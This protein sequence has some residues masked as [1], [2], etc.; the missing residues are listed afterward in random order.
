MGSANE[1]IQKGLQKV[2]DKRFSANIY[3][4]PL[5]VQNTLM[6]SGSS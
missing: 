1:L 4:R 5:I 2:T 6:F 3:N